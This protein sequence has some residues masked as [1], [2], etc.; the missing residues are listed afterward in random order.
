MTVGKFRVQLWSCCNSG[1]LQSVCIKGILGGKIVKLEW[2]QIME[3]LGGQAV[4]IEVHFVR[5]WEPLK[6]FFKSGNNTV[7]ASLQKRLTWQPLFTWI[8]EK[9]WEVGDPYRGPSADNAA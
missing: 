8:R 9:S 6:G 1:R 7:K 5:H 2:S 4:D 3:A